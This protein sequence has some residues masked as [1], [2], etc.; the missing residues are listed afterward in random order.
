[1][2]PRVEPGWYPLFKEYMMKR[3]FLAL[4]AA[5]VALVLVTGCEKS[6]RTIGPGDNGEVLPGEPDQ[7]AI[8][9]T[10]PPLLANG[11]DQVVVHAT[12]VDVDGNGL[13]GVGVFFTTSRGTIE[14]FATTDSEGRAQTT[15]TSSASST[16]IDAIVTA[17]APADSGVSAFAATTI[18]VT[19][20]PPTPFV[21][22]EAVHRQLGT[23]GV[24]CSAALRESSVLDQVTVRMIGVSLSIE[25][26]PATIPADGI[27][28]SQIAA[29]LVETTSRIPLE[30]EEVR[31]GAST[32][33]ITG[34]VTADETGLAAAYLTA[35]PGETFS[36]ISV[37]YGKTLTADTEVVFS[38][39][40]LDTRVAAT[41]L[42]ADGV[43]STEVTA[44]L[45][46]EEGNP[47]STSRRPLGP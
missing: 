35:T 15:L 28:K 16:D 10:F 21:V 26:H 37:F 7:L 18:V 38:P 31:F 11:V 32:G 25:A 9:R 43:S 23:A 14:P 33:S 41:T 40:S 17:R 44:L 4:S 24:S 42:V 29:T 30:G 13:S 6:E 19:S 27:T 34:R 39:L 36:M 46:N 47:V 22:R 12:V 45:V 3:F 5:T 2:V 8:A 20:T 1:M